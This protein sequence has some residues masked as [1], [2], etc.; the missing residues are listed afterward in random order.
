M[1]PPFA[2]WKADIKD[3]M[4]TCVKKRHT[5]FQVNAGILDTMKTGCD[6]LSKLCLVNVNIQRIHGFLMITEKLS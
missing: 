1:H 2:R 6:G 3:V 5:A 4:Y